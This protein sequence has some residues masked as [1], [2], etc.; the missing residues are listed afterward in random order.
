MLLYS[1]PNYLSEDVEAS[2]MEAD[3]T[4]ILNYKKIV[5]HNYR[6]PVLYFGQSVAETHSTVC[7][8]N[9]MIQI[10]VVKLYF[11]EEMYQG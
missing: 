9:Y 1:S 7:L 5:T 6:D 8:Q 2:Y 11:T 3:A 10:T 4:A